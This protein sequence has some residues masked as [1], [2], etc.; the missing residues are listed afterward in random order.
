MSHTKED[1]RELQNKTLEEKIQISTARIIEWY[2]GWGG[3]VCV[4]FSGGKDSTVLLDLVRRIYPDVP[5]VFSDTG[6]EFPETREFVKSFDNVVWLKPEINFSKVLE[7]YGYPIISKSVSDDVHGAKPGNRRWKSLHGINMTKKGTPSLFNSKKWEFLLKADFR[8]SASCC[9]VMKKKPLKKYYKETG[10]KPFVGILT[11]ESLRRK[12]QWLQT[13]CNAFD[14]IEPISTPIAFWNEQDILHYIQK[15]NIPCASV[16]G[17]LKEINNT[18]SFTK[19][20]RTGCTFCAYGCHLEK[21]PNRF[22][23]MAITHPSI[24]DYCMR[25]GKYDE[26]GM[27][28]PD[29]GLGMAKVLD[30]IN[31]KW[32]NDGDEEKRDEYRRIYHEKEEAEKQRKLTESETNE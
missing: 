7:K 4:S 25:G 30:Y 15:Y 27:W 23:Q 11:E 2:E 3:Q 5:A 19:Y 24:Y 31:V 13:G 29:K 1:L 10:K 28:I 21:E 32:W 18:L 17:E 20:Q 9:D 14:L 6:L 22:Q 8:I 26:S 16:Y 12:T